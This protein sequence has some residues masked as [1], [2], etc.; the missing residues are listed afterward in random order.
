[1]KVLE[2][3]RAVLSNTLSFVRVRLWDTVARAVE[4]VLR[5]G[6]AIINVVSVEVAVAAAVWCV[7]GHDVESRRAEMIYVLMESFE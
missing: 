3:Q 7:S 1:M 6:I 4:S 5:R 2:K